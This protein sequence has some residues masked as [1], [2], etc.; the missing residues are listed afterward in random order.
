MDLSQILSN[1]KKQD[2][3]A[4][5][6]LGWFLSYMFTSSYVSHYLAQFFLYSDQLQTEYFFLHKGAKIIS[7]FDDILSM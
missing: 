5:K 7:T 2:L 3:S 1:S 6:C 4:C